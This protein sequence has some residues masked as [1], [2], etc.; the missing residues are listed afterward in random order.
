MSDAVSAPT[1]LTPHA[2]PMFRDGDGLERGSKRKREKE[3]LDPRKSKRPE[4]PVTGPGKGGRVGAS[5][6]Q[7]VVQNLVRDTTRDED[8]REALLR[9][10]NADEDPVWTAAWRANQPKAVFAQ[11]EEEEEEDKA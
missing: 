6:T 5:A 10:A 4:L 7:H 3:R 11:V 9:L 2:L 8:P 1:I